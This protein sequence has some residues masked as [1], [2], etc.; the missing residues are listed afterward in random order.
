[1]KNFEISVVFYIENTV[2]I[3]FKV[4]ILKFIAFYSLYNYKDGG[5]LYLRKEK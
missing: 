3:Q 4:N 5:K 2:E 1:M